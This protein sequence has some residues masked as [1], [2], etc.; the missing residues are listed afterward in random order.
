MISV[1]RGRVTYYLRYIGHRHPQA[2]INGVDDAAVNDG[3]ISISQYCVN[4]LSPYNQVMHYFWTL[5][6][7]WG[8]CLDCS[9]I[10]KS[11]IQVGCHVFVVLI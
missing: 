1:H 7:L 2:T 3:L 4:K 8:L 5:V 10:A 11:C 6:Q 9:Y